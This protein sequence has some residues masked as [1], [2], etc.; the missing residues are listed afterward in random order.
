MKIMIQTVVLTMICI[1]LSHRL[2]P[3]I[4]MKIPLGRV[5]RGIFNFQTVPD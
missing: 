4:D 2:K 5:L 3:T 1:Y